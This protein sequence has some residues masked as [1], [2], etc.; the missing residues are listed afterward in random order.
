[1]LLLFQV[2]SLETSTQMVTATEFLSG[3]AL[4][5]TI[6]SEGDGADGGRNVSCSPV[7][8]TF[9]RQLRKPQTC[10]TRTARTPIGHGD[11]RDFASGGF[12]WYTRGGIGLGFGW[13]GLATLCQSSPFHGP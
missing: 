13:S 3:R 8:Q 9:Y 10:P 12:S 6:W 11:G 4:G 5:T 1:M 7:C 2:Y